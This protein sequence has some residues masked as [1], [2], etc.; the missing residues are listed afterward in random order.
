MQPTVR[1]VL[2]T[3]LTEAELLARDRLRVRLLNEA[4][5]P[6]IKALL[7]LVDVPEMVLLQAETA[8]EEAAAIR[9]ALVVEVDPRGG[10]ESGNGK[11]LAD[12]LPLLYG[13]SRD[14]HL[15]LHH[16]TKKGDVLAAD[17]LA[18]EP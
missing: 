3:S 11:I 15:I 8:S 13:S 18:Y 1:L 4:N 10:P 17:L 12:V 7:R 2:S 9:H 16:L 6:T 14:V 5:K